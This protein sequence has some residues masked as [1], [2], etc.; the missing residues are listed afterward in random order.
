M[1]IYIVANS[2]NI[3]LTIIDSPNL[4]RYFWYTT[5]LYISLVLIGQYLQMLVLTKLNMANFLIQGQITDSSGL[6]SSII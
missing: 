2:P 3:G 4:I 6:I 1:G 5:T